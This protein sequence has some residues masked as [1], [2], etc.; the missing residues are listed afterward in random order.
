MVGLQWCKVG[1]AP[2]FKWHVRDIEDIPGTCWYCGQEDVEVCL[3]ADS[4]LQLRRDLGEWARG[5]RRTGDQSWL[6]RRRTHVRE[7]FDQ[8]IGWWE[9]QPNPSPEL[10]TLLKEYHDR[11]RPQTDA[12]RQETSRRIEHPQGERLHPD[13]LH[14]LTEQLKSLAEEERTTREST[15]PKGASSPGSWRMFSDPPRPSSDA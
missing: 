13:R 10:R 2:R 4:L 3:V 11:G 14:E 12:P 6:N 8:V 9:R 7:R 1:D 15:K 5:N